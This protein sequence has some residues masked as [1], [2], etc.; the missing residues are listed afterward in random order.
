MVASWLSVHSNQARTLLL[1]WSFSL[2]LSFCTSGYQIAGIEIWNLDVLNP[3]EPVTILGGR[4]KQLSAMSRKAEKEEEG[5][6]S[7]YV[8]GSGDTK[9][10]VSSS[11]KKGGKAANSKKKKKYASLGCHVLV[12][13]ASHNSVF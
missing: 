7:Q 12:S 3:V 10:D 2:I 9:D 5:G 6:G 4:P 11:S 8:K 13:C 1:A